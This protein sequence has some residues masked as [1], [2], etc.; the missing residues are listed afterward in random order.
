VAS[1]PI[2]PTVIPPGL[3]LDGAA[4][5]ASQGAI[6]ALDAATSAL[7]RSYPARGVHGDPVAVGAETLYAN[8]NHID[9]RAVLAMRAVDGTPLWRHDTAEGL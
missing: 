2:I 8:L 4:I 5:Y 7:L 3:A 1:E 9:E 6:Y